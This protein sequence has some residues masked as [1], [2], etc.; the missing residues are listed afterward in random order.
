[1]RLATSP[2]AWLIQRGDSVGSVPELTGT[3]ARRRFDHHAD[4]HADVRCQS[5]LVNAI[6]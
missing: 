4:D 5:S 2:L 6:S 3:T 1:M